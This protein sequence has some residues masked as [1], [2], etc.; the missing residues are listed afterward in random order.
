MHARTADGLV[1][2]H[3][4]LAL[5]E[6]VQHH[7]HRAQVQ[8]IGPQPHQ[9]V[10]DPG[11]L[12]EHRADVLGA[13]GR[14]DAHQLLDGQHVGVLVAHHRHIVQTIH[15]ADRLVER[16]GLGQFFG[17][18]VQQADVWVGTDDGFAVHLQDQAQHA[19]RG[20]MLRAEVHR[21]VADFLLAFVG[22]A[23][24]G[25]V[26]GLDVCTHGLGSRSAAS[27]AAVW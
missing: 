11:D 9:V 5:A 8:R 1:A 24:E 14:L 21:V 22:V 26:G 20:R 27:P 18:P 3:Q 6:A 19:V 4:F 2:V 7:R 17:A 23:G 10:Q 25:F 12:V 15:V 13:L 16:L